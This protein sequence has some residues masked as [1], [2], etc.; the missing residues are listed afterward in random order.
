ME[1]KRKENK[2]KISGRAV[3]VGE[4]KTAAEELRQTLAV[5]HYEVRRPG[6]CFRCSRFNAFRLL[7]LVM[8]SLVSVCLSA[9]TFVEQM[10]DACMKN[11]NLNYIF[12]N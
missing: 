9:S 7:F 6:K 11:D 12:I 10:V 4:T 1:F 8:F 3:A 2:L 5:A